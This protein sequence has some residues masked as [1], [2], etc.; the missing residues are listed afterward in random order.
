VIS[1]K[2]GTRTWSTA[3]QTS[4]LRGD[5]KQTMS[6][7]DRDQL[8]NGEDLGTHLNKIADP[9]YVDPAKMRKVGNNDLDR[10]AFLKMFLAQLKNQD[11]TNPMQ[12]HELAAQ[13]A[14]FTSLEKLNNIDTGITQMAKQTDPNKGYDALNLI[15]KGVSGDSGK[16]FRSDMKSSHEIT[17]NLA[18]SAQE[19]ELSVRNSA[20]QEIKKLIARGLK[21]GANRVPWDGMIE[22]GSAAPE[23]EYNV[24]ITAKNG[25]GQ[26]VAAETK[27]QGRVT[28]VNFSPEGPVLMVGKQSIKLSDVKS[29]FESESL[30]PQAQLVKAEAQVG[31]DAKNLASGAPQMSGNLESVGMSQDLINRLEKE[32]RP[33]V[34]TT[35]EMKR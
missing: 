5:G 21:S 23:G 32:A 2:G 28:G 11:P 31:K 19:V 29:I 34:D 30:A 8:L 27:F 1:V 7:Q 12:N 16:I 26:K 13:L 22:S 9:N 3:E 24:T 35:E 33:K 18:G 15:G 4:S 10:D 6:A 20:G 14:Q 25:T 17:F